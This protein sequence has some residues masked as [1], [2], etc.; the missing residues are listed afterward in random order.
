MPTGALR[1]RFCVTAQSRMCRPQPTLIP[2]VAALSMAMARS[3]DLDGPML[4]EFGFAALIVGSTISS[5]GFAALAYADLE[6]PIVGLG[7]ILAG[8][9]GATATSALRGRREP[10]SMTP[11]QVVAGRV[12]G[13][14]LIVAAFAE[15]LRILLME[16]A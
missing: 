5:A 4:R 11:Q 3:L 13:A 2:H 14:L 8:I 6:R 12:A 7:G 10:G 1:T 16:R 9:V 15:P